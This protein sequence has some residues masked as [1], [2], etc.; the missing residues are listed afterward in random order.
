MQ[1]WTQN[2]CDSVCCRIGNVAG[3][4]F[5]TSAGVDACI[6]MNC[7]WWHLTVPEISAVCAQAERMFYGFILEAARR[8]R[9]VRALHTSKFWIQR[10]LLVTARQVHFNENMF[11]A[12]SHRAPWFIA[13]PKSI[14]YSQPSITE[15]GNYLRSSAVHKRRYRKRDTRLSLIPA[16]LCLRDVLQRAINVEKLKIR[17]EQPQGNN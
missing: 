14:N 7:S 9:W 16:P 3:W 15:K 12:R 17:R 2:C 4:Y 1:N 11:F 10:T 13:P 5:K 6:Q 8:E